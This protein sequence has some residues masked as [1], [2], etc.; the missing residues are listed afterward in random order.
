MLFLCFG[1]E[2]AHYRPD[3]VQP[4]SP[5]SWLYGL[6][7]SQDDELEKGDAVIP[8]CKKHDGEG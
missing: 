6:V 1:V 2:I 8:P 3:L 7:G 5:L 4:I